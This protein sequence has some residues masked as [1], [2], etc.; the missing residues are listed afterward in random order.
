MASQEEIYKIDSLLWLFKCYV[1]NQSFISFD[2]DLLSK[3]VIIPDNAPKLV[4]YKAEKIYG[5]SPEQLNN[6]FHKDY[7]TVAEADLEV[8]IN[9]QLVNYI[10]TY[11]FEAL[12]MEA[13]A[14]VPNEELNIVKLKKVFTIILPITEKEVV[15]K[16]T[17][18]VNGFALSAS[19]LDYISTLLSFIK[20]PEKITNRE[21]KCLWYINNNDVPED[22]DDVIRIMIFNSCG[23]TLKIKS[24]E[25]LGELKNGNTDLYTKMLK[26]YIKKYS[27][28]N[29]AETW[30]RNKEYFLTIKTPENANIINRARKLAYKYYKPFVTPLLLQA[31]TRTFANQEFN[32]FCEEIK[33]ADIYKLVTLYNALMTMNVSLEN[34]CYIVRNGKAYIKE[35]KTCYIHDLTKKIN[36]V[37]SEIKNRIDLSGKTFYIPEHVEY[38]VPTTEKQFL[39]T[40]P[41]GTVITLPRD[42]AIVAGIHWFDYKKERT[43]LDLHATDKNGE[44]FG[45]NSSYRTQYNKV[46]FTGDMTSA[47]A[48]NGASEYFYIEKDYNDSM[49]LSLTNYTRKDNSPYELIIATADH[50][51]EE[52]KGYNVNPNNILLKL[53]SRVK[54]SDI[55]GVVS[56][57][58]D[59]V[60]F[61]VYPQTID[62]GIGGCQQMF[63]KSLV[64]IAENKLSKYLKLDELIEVCGG[65]VTNE[66]SYAYK[67]IID[68]SLE[69]ISQDTL[70]NI[71]TGDNNE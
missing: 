59:Y 37:V 29:I 1:D 57:Q 22:I 65:K 10:T 17:K 47:P 69:S 20:S 5:V 68:L 25:V 43:D 67:D 71:I 38:T 28:K 11:G 23:S 13:D 15:D 32:K 14:Y 49:L 7:N 66:K 62:T 44:S 24:K 3:G 16:V 19:T 56:L 64:D 33:N 9:Q 34:D 63:S 12:G 18:F 60:K 41:L 42:K 21:V 36:I 50:K 2:S 46:L 27:I 35:H 4:K 6:S 54:T 70:L 51:K 39:G 55:I 26:T 40:V 52:A 61:I 8:L 48:P 58:E 45:W 31:T 30:Y 53:S